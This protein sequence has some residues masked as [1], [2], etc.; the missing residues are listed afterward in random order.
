MLIW[1]NT[2]KFVFIFKW[3]AKIRVGSEIK[4]VWWWK[5]ALNHVWHC[6]CDGKVPEKKKKKKDLS[7]AH[8]QWKQEQNLALDEKSKWNHHLLLITS[9]NT[10][11]HSWTVRQHWHSDYQSLS[12]YNNSHL[13]PKEIKKKKRNKFLILQFVN[14]C[15]TS[16]HAAEVLKYTNHSFSMVHQ[17]MPPGLTWCESQYAESLLH[18]CLCQIY[19]W[20]QTQRCVAVKAAVKLSRST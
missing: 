19:V 2:I 16:K 9:M 12:E 10:A 8:N 14:E 17:A 20:S 3:V 5:I 4:Q 1:K 18:R 11:R 15:T 13:F 6:S 7:Y